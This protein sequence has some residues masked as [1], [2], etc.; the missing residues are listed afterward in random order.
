MNLRMAA[1]AGLVAATA[2]AQIAVPRSVIHGGGVP[3]HTFGSLS[4]FGNVVFPGTGGPP[5]IV[6]PGFGRPIAP[7]QRSIY[8]GNRGAI[9]VPYAVPVYVGDW[10]DSYVRQPVVTQAAPAMAPVVINNYYTPPSPQ[11]VMRDYSETPLP[12][13][14]P[15][16]LQSYQAPTPRPSVAE[17]KATIYLIALKDGTIHAA[18]GYWLEKDT[19]NYITTQGSHNRVSLELVNVSFSEQLNRERSVEFKIE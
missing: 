12:E 18:Y 8:R 4:G 3:A 5:P 10:T 2:S 1:I 6:N 9:A 7:A 15:Q 13:A 14:S 19:L 16:R 11:P 17:E